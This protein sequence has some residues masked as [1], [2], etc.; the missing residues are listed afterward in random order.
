MGACF[1]ACGASYPALTS[2]L[3]GYKL[4]QVS[5]IDCCPRFVQG[6]HKPGP[7]SG[8]A[9]RLAVI[10]SPSAAREPPRPVSSERPID[11]AGVSNSRALWLLLAT[12]QSLYLP[13]F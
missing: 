3:A 6:L 7:A 5:G 4:L 12:T 10:Y 8:A 9:L 1:L 13:A 2:S 11:A